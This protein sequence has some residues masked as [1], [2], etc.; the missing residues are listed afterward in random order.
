ML[1]V[2]T[3]VVFGEARF[4]A[5]VAVVAVN[6]FYSHATHPYTDLARRDGLVFAYSAAR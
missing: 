5:E 1:L 3:H 4:L 2:S 6:L